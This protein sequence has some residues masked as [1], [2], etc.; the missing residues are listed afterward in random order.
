MEN[1]KSKTVL[2]VMCENVPDI[3]YH[4]DFNKVL[5]TYQWPTA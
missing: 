5:L 3:K 1:R 4:A 2:S